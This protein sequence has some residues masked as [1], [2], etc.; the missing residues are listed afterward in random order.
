M[1]ETIVWRCEEQDAG[2]RIDACLA[3]H[4]ELSRSR[5]ATLMAEGALTIDGRPER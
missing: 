1:S 5:I 4:T 2:T 3:A